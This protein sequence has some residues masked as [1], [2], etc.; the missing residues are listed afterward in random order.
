[1]VLDETESKNNFELIGHNT[2]FNKSVTTC[3]PPPPRPA[4]P[5]HI[6]IEDETPAEAIPTAD[7]FNLK[8]DPAAT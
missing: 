7:F 8:Q 4:P 3:V 5:K 1:M 6:P 2:E